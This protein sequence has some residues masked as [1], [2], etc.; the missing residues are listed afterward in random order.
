MIRVFPWL[1]AAFVFIH[2][3]LFKR[4]LDF[5]LLVGVLSNSAGAYEFLSDIPPD[6]WVDYAQPRPRYGHTTTSIAE[7][8][9]HGYDDESRSAPLHKFVQL[10]LLR[11]AKRHHKHLLEARRHAVNTDLPFTPRAA[12][13]LMGNIKVRYPTPCIG[14]LSVCLSTKYIMPI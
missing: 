2:I 1:I 4:V 7:S 11:I 12:E 9:N 13:R 3:I 8:V 10:A 6:M 5:C 14:S